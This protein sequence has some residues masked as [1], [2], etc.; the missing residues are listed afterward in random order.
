[1]AGASYQL[2]TGAGPAGVAVIR[3]M[4]D[5]SEFFRRHVRLR[6]AGG[7]PDWQSLCDTR[8]VL[9][10][11]LVETDGEPLDDILLS[12]HAAQPLDLRLH[13]HGGPWLVRTASERM[14]ASG[15]T[16]AAAPQALWDCADAIAREAFDALPRMATLRGARWLLS[17]VDLLR[18][19]LDRLANQER[20]DD[21]RRE[22]R[23]IAGRAGIID[24]FARPLRI[25]LA[26]PPNAGKSTLVNALAGSN[27]SIV[28]PTPGTTRDWVEAP[29]EL[30]GYPALWIDTAG[31]RTTDDSLE[32]AGIER[33]HE[34]IRRADAVVVV[35]DA[36]SAAAEERAAFICAYADVRPTC[37]AF[38]K[39]D[40]LT[41]RP[42]TLAELAQS[43]PKLWRAA[44]RLVSGLRGEGLPDLRASLC[45]ELGRTDDLLA[46]PAAFASRQ[47][48][49]LQQAHAAADRKSFME[50]ILRTISG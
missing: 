15:M 18:S 19:A 11:D 29:G 8:R 20:D 38:N 33:T 49:L 37:V 3:L 35:L 24:W 1:M 17:Q 6:L 25:V 45:R 7:I 2:L 5:C 10:A 32:V 34:L 9:R 48:I 23:E 50:R 46:L 26:G 12:V 43:L 4:G 44:A 28:S 27:V 16:E 40:L 36:A 42:T 41:A 13:L 31:L 39:S 47:A 14:R 30:D 22:C 21:A